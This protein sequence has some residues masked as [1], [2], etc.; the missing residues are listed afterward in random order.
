MHPDLERL[1][2]LNDLD[3]TFDQV[4]RALA[5]ARAQV[6]VAK[7]VEATAA[8]ARDAIKAELEATRVEERAL[9]RKVEEYRTRQRGAVNALNNGHGDPVV[10]Q[11]QLDQCTAIIDEAETK[12][13]EVMEK[14]DGLNTRLKAAEVELASTVDARKQAEAAAPA[15]IGRLDAQQADLKR[16]RDAVSDTLPLELRSRYDVLRAGKKKYGVARVEKDGTCRGCQMAIGLQQ[17]SDIRRG[18]ILPCRGCGRW[19]V[20]I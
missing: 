2:A 19:V 8:A 15:A 14:Q 4:T 10:A 7:G 11:R 16:Q 3:V 17:V 18:L 5:T 13:L 1:V 6:D 20:P 9:Q 12:T